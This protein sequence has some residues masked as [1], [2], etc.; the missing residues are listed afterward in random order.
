MLPVSSHLSHNHTL[1]ELDE[2]ADRC[3]VVLVLLEDREGE[4]ERVQVLNRVAGRADAAA[5]D[6]VRGLDGLAVAVEDD[7]LLQVGEHDPRDGHVVGGGV[8][9]EADPNLD[10]SWFGRGL[11]G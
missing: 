4:K 2:L 8:R 11:P 7:R 9:A 6:H 10:V 5:V 1:D 3:R